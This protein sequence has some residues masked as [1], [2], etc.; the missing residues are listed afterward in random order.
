MLA[1]LLGKHQKEIRRE[2]HSFVEPWYHD[3]AK[4]G[5]VL[6]VWI[7]LT[8]FLQTVHNSAVTPNV[9]EIS[10]QTI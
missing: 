8:S 3:C 7:K 6:G 9:V 4:A 2:R 1:V 10:F 5:D